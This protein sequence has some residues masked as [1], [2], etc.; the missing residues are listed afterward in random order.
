M[1]NVDTG[2]ESCPFCGGEAGLEFAN[3]TFSFTDYDGEPKETGFFYTVKCRDEIC[4]CHI[5]AYKDPKMAVAAWNR[6]EPQIIYCKDCVRKCRFYDT[7]GDY[8]YCRYGKD[9][10]GRINSQGRNS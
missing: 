7:Q 6:R 9:E 10:Y 8:G 3:K 2:L 4:G 5:G 1:I